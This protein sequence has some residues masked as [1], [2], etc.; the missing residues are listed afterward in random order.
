MHDIHTIAL[1]DIDADALPRDRISLAPSALAEL[2]ASIASLG[3]THP[4]EVWAKHDPLPDT[5]RHGLISGL[6]RLTAVR[7]LGH[8][9]IP[10]FIRDPS[11]IAE[12][13]TRMVTENEIRAAISP[14]EKGRLVTESVAEG[15]FPTL[16]AAT[17]SLYR[18]LDRH[19]RAR[20]R[21]M[22]DVVAE[23]GDHLLTAPEALSQ[24]QITRI[25]F[26]LRADLGPLITTALRTSKQKSPDA[27]WKTILPILLEAEEAARTP[28]TA[29]YRP[30]RPRRT[31]Q[32]RSK[33]N[34]RRERTPDGWSLRF[35]GPEATGPLMEDIM[36]A[37]EDQFG[38]RQR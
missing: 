11:D 32:V 5:P 22:A 13:M 25:A 19:R 24:N 1:T 8:T 15:L 34:I 33:L 2:Q 3:L 20:I 30:G 12:A 6:R 31:A 38:N 27:Q 10:A 36:D 21:A 26:A 4:I 7:A 18:T 23:I 35:T 17:D 29:L 14:W 28:D 37:V 16:D 9:T